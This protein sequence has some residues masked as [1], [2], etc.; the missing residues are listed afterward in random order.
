MLFERCHHCGYDLRGRD[1]TDHPVRCPECGTEQKVGART[2]LSLRSRSTGWALLWGLLPVLA[3]LVSA[4]VARGFSTQYR[5]L[6]IGTPICVL[7]GGAIACWAKKL[8]IDRSGSDW[9]RHE[10]IGAGLR[11]AL[12][13][14]SVNAL[15]GAA[16]SWGILFLS[17]V[18]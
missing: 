11:L 10:R 15:L 4:A 7:V 9:P 12:L 18:T 14:L 6:I 17:L 1:W 3:V 8:L 13:S 2:E 16:G 5:V